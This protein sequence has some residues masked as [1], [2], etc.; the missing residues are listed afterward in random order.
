M[1]TNDLNSAYIYERERRSDERRAAAESQWL[2]EL[3]DKHKSSLPSPMT[4]IG[5]LVM[6]I[7]IIR[8]L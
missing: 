1:Y 4:I 6:F 2:R 3:G 5:I 8:V 7:I